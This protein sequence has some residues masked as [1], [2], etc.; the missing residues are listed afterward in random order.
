MPFNADI[1]AALC[2]SVSQVGIP[3]GGSTL[4]GPAADRIWR[5]AYAECV[6]A[7]RAAGLAVDITVDSMA[8]DYMRDAESLLTSG[9]ALR[10]A[11]A[12]GTDEGSSKAFIDEG[13]AKLAALPRPDVY[14]SL[15]SNG[16]TA[17]TPNASPW[18]GSQWA[19]DADP[20]Y[21]DIAG[22]GDRPY[23]I[24]PIVFEGDPT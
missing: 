10:G 11:L 2:Y 20:D 24:P 5:G 1:V 3:D 17:S 15:I 12:V 22:T 16:A 13:L 14:G 7:L 23:V 19:D 21:D 9:R 18:V 6:V 4:P 8:R